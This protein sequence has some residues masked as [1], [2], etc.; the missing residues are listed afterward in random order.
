M[1][2]IEVDDDVMAH[3]TNHARPFK[4]TPNSVLRKLLLGHDTSSPLATNRAMTIQAAPATSRLPLTAKQS[5]G[6]FVAEIL[7]DEFGEQFKVRSPYQMMFESDLRLVYFQ[8]FNKAGTSNLWFRL[9]PK[10]M[11]ALRSS[12]KPS[13]VIFTNP[14]DRYA[15][16]LPL[17]DLDARIHQNGWTR[18]ELE[19]NIDPATLRWREFDWDLSP[20]RKQY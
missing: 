9:H 8:N 14:A 19:V 16:V 17:T 10:P 11:Q 3:L 1:H 2:Q 4:D 15:F 13:F 5:P 7:A 18:P 20:Y 6:S 12:R